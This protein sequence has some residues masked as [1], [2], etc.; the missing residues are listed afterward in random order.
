MSE[1][2]LGARTSREAMSPLVASC[3][4]VVEAHAADD[5]QQEAMALRELYRHLADCG[6][7]APR[8]ASVLLRLQAVALDIACEQ[9]LNPQPRRD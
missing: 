6:W 1:A 5:P 2:D 7:V 8:R 3:R 4:W 9:L